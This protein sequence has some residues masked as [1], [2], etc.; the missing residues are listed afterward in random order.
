MAKIVTLLEDT[1]Y[2]PKI[3]ACLTSLGHQIRVAGSAEQAIDLAYLFDPD[4]LIADSRLTGEYSG[5]EV[6]EAF[7]YAT[8]NRPNGHFQSILLSE[9]TVKEWGAEYYRQVTRVLVQPLSISEFICELND[10][11]ATVKNEESLIRFS[12]N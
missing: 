6:V 4:V 2:A 3:E 1:A 10:L 11:L 5:I 12:M 7:N 9:C 8:R